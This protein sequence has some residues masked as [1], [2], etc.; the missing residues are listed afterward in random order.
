[1]SESKMPKTV[2]LID[3]DESITDLIAHA[4]K[5]AGHTVTAVNDGEEGV[6][7]ARKMKPEVVVVDLQMPGMNGFE[8]LMAI[9]SDPTLTQTRVI[10]QSGKNYPAD[11]RSAAQLGAS[12]YMVK[13]VR[14][15]ELLAEI[16]RSEP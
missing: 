6:V 5:K 1:M 11:K 14:I 7:A 16:D 13:P 4:L 15:K 10:V 12:A 9:R 3:D 8:V 2:L